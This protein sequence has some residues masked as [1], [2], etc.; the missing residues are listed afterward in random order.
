MAPGVDGKIVKKLQDALAEIA[1]DPA[2]IEEMD[3]YSVNAV[4]EPAEESLP[5][6][7]EGR[8]AIAKFLS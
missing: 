7:L 1:A 3:G 2:F 8:D 6:L 4:F 5:K